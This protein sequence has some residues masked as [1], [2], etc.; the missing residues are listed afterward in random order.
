MGLPLNG[1]S[2]SQLATLQVGVA[3]AAAEQ[4][5]R[6]GGGGSM[7]VTGGRFFSNN[8]LLDGT[9]I[10]DTSNLVPRSAA[11]VQLGSDAV[12]QVQV[13]APHYG[14]EYGRSSGAV[15][16]SITRSGS[17]EFH[18][19][20]FEYFRNSKL[21]ARNFFDPGDP[22]PFKRNQFGFTLTGP[23]RK[24][25]TYFMGSYEAM[26]D[27]LSETAVD[28]FPDAEARQGIITDASG[29][30]IRTVFVDPRVKPYL[31]LYPLPNAARIGRGVGQSRRPQFLPTNENFL[32]VRVDHKISD[33]D[34]FFA[35]Y[36]FDD[37]VS[38]TS[39]KTFLFSVRNQTR[40]QFFTLV[41]SHIFNPR[42]LSSFRFGFTRPVA[43]AE[44]ISDIPI[45]RSLFFVPD[46]PQF[47][48]LF[49][50]P[51]SP[52]GPPPEL[53]S[54]NL[55]NSFQI[56]GDLLAQRGAHAL[57]FGVEI[58]GYRWKV[59]SSNDRSAVWSFT[60]LENFLTAGKE[61]GVSLRVT[62][63]GSDNTK[64]YRQTLAGFYIQDAYSLTPRLQLSLGLRYEF[65]TLL[66]D[67]DG[68]T[69]FFSDPLR[70]PTIQIG[71]YLTHNPSRRNFSPRL[72]L[73]WSPFAGGQTVLRGGFGIYYDE[74][75]AYVADSLKNSVPFHK[76][77]MRV[78][79]DSSTSSGFPNAAT[80]V[81]T[82]DP[83]HPIPF[84][85]QVMDYQ[86][87]R[88]PMVL[89]YS[90][91][92]QQQLPGGWRLQ[93]SY[94]G[95]RGNHLFR[96]YEVNLFP[97]PVQQPDGSL[98]FPDN[99]NDPQNGNPSPLC[100]SG[101]GPVNPAFGGGINLLSSD[102]QSFYNS[103]QL[104]GSKSFGTG[105]SLQASYTY[106]KSIDDASRIGPAPGNPTSGPPSY[107]LQRTLNRG[108]SDF[109]IRHRLAVSYF[110]T[111]PLGAGQRWWN[112]GPLAHLLGGWRLGGIVSVRSGVPFSPF[113][114]MVTPGYLFA[115]LRPNLLPGKS[116]NPVQGVSE[117][118]GP[119]K[120]GQ[121]LGG[122]DRYF[123]PCVFAPPAAGT[124]GTAG[125]NTIIAP[126]VFSVDLSLQKEFI[127]PGKKRLQFRAEMFNVPN[128]TN[129]NRVT[130]G[131]TQVFLGNPP[132]VSPTSGVINST[133]TT[134][135]QIQFALR[136]SL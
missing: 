135:R 33:R 130:G 61:G 127:L 106:G 37:A 25:N 101:A 103:L 110:Y 34:S 93:A 112:S 133:T 58:H 5:S 82:S 122:A 8:F 62:L 32:T 94:V 27:R 22:P 76:V 60:N 24:D 98:F 69:A 63:P 55:M 89:R 59:F 72:G 49:H 41:E 115:P 44:A 117:G 51:A 90:L 116:N 29:N 13:L 64:N 28:Y 9:N 113:L 30:V 23:L 126:T 136:L 50:S 67:K 77:A 87:I 70:D 78:N 20:F 45:P 92:L 3:D 11:G 118:C 36:T 124:L 134:A 85:A 132:H 68:K 114:N 71:P 7:T 120:A 80:A 99:C 131:S 74:L 53:P 128:R 26:R 56:S 19:N 95:S 73:T 81:A 119:V 35:R 96:S 54:R 104:S 75:L 107:E 52:F 108:L 88:S 2:Y 39:D 109:D 100:Q 46:A 1:R 42:V 57:K 16:N 38:D 6:G 48:Q 18:G 123:D 86:G 111:L 121:A 40:Q 84:Q 17:D 4:S 97:T 83:I 66:Q 65:A 125:R 91:A 12:F 79:F 47:G 129:L 14:A 31:E 21:D 15:L 102:A 10:M 43:A 105:I